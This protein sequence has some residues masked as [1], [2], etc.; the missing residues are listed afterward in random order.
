MDT[1][2]KFDLHIHTVASARTKDGDRTIVANSIIDNLNVLVEAL[3]ANSVNMVALTDHN[4]FDKKIYLKLKE[5]EQEGNCIHKVLP[6]VEIDLNIDGKMVH[7]VCIFD[8]TAPNYLEKIDSEFKTQS[9]YTVDQL[10]AML[11]KIEL[12]TVLIAHQKCDY[13]TEKQQKTSLS[14]A[15]KEQF[16]KFIGCEFFDALEIQNTKVEGILKSRFSNDSISNINLVV[17]SDCHDWNAYPA[18]H[19]HR[20]P[21]ELMYI[22]ALPTF[23]G[24]VMAITDNSRIYKYIEPNKE[25]TLKELVLKIDEVEKTIP[26]SDKINVIIGDNSVGKST[27][28]KYLSGI[29]EKGAI[30]FLK[31][32]G[33][34]IISQPLKTE[35][36][37]FSGQGKI[38][39]MFE[40]S[41]EKL[42]LKQKFSSLFK[43]ID[44]K[45]YKDN[46]MMVLKYYERVWEKN[47]KVVNNIQAIQKN[48]YVP[49]FTEKDKHY[50]S[51]ESNLIKQVNEY[52]NLTKIFV[53]I[54]NKFKDFNTY[55][56]LIEKDD[57]TGLIEVRNA[58]IQIGKKY[59]AIS[60]DREIDLA[61][62][63][64]FEY[65]A[66]NYTD[67]INQLSGSDEIMLNC[68]RNEYQKA[69]ES[70]CLDLEYKFS[71]IESVWNNFKEFKVQES[72]NQK[73]KY[74]FVDKAVKNQTITQKLIIEYILRFINTQKPLEQLTSSEILASIKGKRMNEK[75]AENISE[76]LNIVYDNF[77]EDNMTT[78]V[79]IKQGNDI[80]SE[81]NSA[82]INALYYI[83]ILSETYNKPIFI[84]DQPED[85]VSQSRISSNLI[86]SLKRLAT[87]SQIIIVTH[88]PQLVV[89]LDADNIIVIKKEDK[90]I[91]FFSGPLEYVMDDISILDLVAKTLDGGADVIKKRWKRYDKTGI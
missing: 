48:I 70:I 33:I 20:P 79:E 58:L 60:I 40:A 63:S 83:D 91:N 90:E 86:A 74:C 14:Y 65:E 77:I 87:R 54:Y 15:G 41:E 57:I 72:I 26:L 19:K 12:G 16:Y 6:G 88:N 82:G 11:R 4:I 29:T 73:G 25:N 18:H 3:I 78:T 22:K 13:T 69:I 61:L 53:E 84:I 59:N 66:K 55:K 37:T 1:Y 51:I 2:T 56:D 36:F 44:L 8:D 39:E 23:Q 24:L 30:E 85:D 62:K 10:G 5:Q 75:T 32:H 34:E 89:N 67:R 17:G 21:A 7:V 52:E 71:T 9:S 43:P 68:Y 42:P 49:I 50:L 81:S 45:P 46:I 31:N 80:L 76:F 38:R 47:D 64:V 35:F 28:V 27:L